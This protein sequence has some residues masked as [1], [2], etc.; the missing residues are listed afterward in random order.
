[1]RQLIDQL[2]HNL[3]RFGQHLGR[4]QRLGQVV[5]HPPIQFGWAG[6]QPDGGGLDHL[7]DAGLD[8]RLLAFKRGQPLL[9]RALKA[10]VPGCSEGSEK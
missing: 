4:G 2:A 1:M 7:G 3:G 8:R 10:A 5:D 9:E 6:V